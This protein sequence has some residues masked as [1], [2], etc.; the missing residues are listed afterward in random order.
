MQKKDYQFTLEE[1][2]EIAAMVPDFSSP[3]FQLF[4][5]D[6]LGSKAIKTMDAAGVGGY[7]LLLIWSWNDKTCGL[8]VNEKFYKLAQ[9]TDEEWSVHGPDIMKNF[10]KVGEKYYNRR[11]L[12]ERKRQILQRFKSIKGGMASVK[13]KELKRLQ[14]LTNLKTG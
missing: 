13:S 10:K 4:V 8:D 11:L 7:L 14:V 5:N 9:M 3:S 1:L 2:V 12:I 6:V